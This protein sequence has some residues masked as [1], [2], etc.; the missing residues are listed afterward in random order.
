MRLLYFILTLFFLFHFGVLGDEGW[1]GPESVSGWNDLRECLRDCI[2]WCNAEGCH[3][4]VAEHLGCNV[5]SVICVCQAIVRK[6]AKDWIFGCAA[7]ACNTTEE[8]SKASDIFDKFCNE[9]YPSNTSV[10]PSE[11]GNTASPLVTTTCT[12]AVHSTAQQGV[13]LLWDTLI[14]LMVSLVTIFGG[15]MAF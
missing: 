8:A 3:G 9:F 5:D 10:D 15:L 14:T 1:P 11:T 2:I 12:E 6:P 7:K 13:T 4:Q